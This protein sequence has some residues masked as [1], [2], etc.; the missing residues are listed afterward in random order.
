MTFT[1]Q[2]LTVRS[3]N[4]LVT[5]NQYDD[6]VV[7][8]L[9]GL[10]G[11]VRVRYLV[12]GYEVAPSTG[13]EHLQCFVQFKNQATFKSVKKFFSV[14]GSPN[15]VVGNDRA[16]KMA[17]Y[18][19]KDGKFE[20]FGVVPISRQ[21]SGRIG[22]STRKVN[23]DR[24]INLA[25]QGKF[26]KIARKFPKQLLAYYSTLRNIHKDF[27]EAKEDLGEPTGV[28]IYGATGVGKSHYA[29]ET[30][31]SWYDKPCNKWWDN[32]KGEDNVLL[33]DFDKKHGVL[34]HHLKRWADR[35]AFSGEIKGSQINLRPKVIV[36]TSQ[37]RIGEIWDDAETVDAL[38]RRFIKIKIHI[39]SQGNRVIQPQGF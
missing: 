32:Y 14:L 10:G 7:N 29:R 27:A 35:Y 22:G 15:L 12:F 11:H 28:W 5:C 37:Y 3:R 23:Y 1:T 18:C 2:S 31:P 26:A 34:A 20:E 19:R 21:E 16:D 33:D 25:V 36:V 9:R 4:W 6:T 38:N 30:Y 13:H 39:D 8:A 17:A 24:V